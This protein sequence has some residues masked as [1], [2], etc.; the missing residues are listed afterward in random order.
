MDTPACCGPSRHAARGSYGASPDFKHVKTL[1]L[2]AIDWESAGLRFIVGHKCHRGPQIRFFTEFFPSLEE[3]P[4][5]QSFQELS[6]SEA[7]GNGPRNWATPREVSLQR[8]QAFSKL[9]V[10]ERDLK[11]IMV[12]KI[13]GWRPPK[14]RIVRSRYDMTE[15]LPNERI[16]HGGSSSETEEIYR[17]IA[18]YN[19]PPSRE[20]WHKFGVPIPDFV[21]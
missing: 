19:K 21:E 14:V 9:C 3:I 17:M 7:P 13:L 15:I 18:S 11:N 1:L 16:P 2:N 8:S 4:L 6:R 10:M 5:A 12:V 20:Y